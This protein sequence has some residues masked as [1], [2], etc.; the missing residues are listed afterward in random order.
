MDI[1]RAIDLLQKALSELPELHTF[2]LGNKE[3]ELWHDKVLDILEETF[4]KSST[5][6]ERFARAVSKE[7]QSKTEIAITTRLRLKA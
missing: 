1:K 4:G 6:W 5:E 7:F 2:S 3:F